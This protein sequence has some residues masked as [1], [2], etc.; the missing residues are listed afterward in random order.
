[1]KQIR[2]VHKS[3]H[4]LQQNAYPE[5]EKIIK[6]RGHYCYQINNN[7]FMHK[8]LILLYKQIYKILQMRYK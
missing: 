1:M 6:K 3:R 2:E 5:I 4:Q 8:K 7:C